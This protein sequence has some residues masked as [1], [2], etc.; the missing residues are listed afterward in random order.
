MEKRLLLKDEFRKKGN[1][2]KMKFG[3]D[4]GMGGRGSS[5]NATKR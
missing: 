2:S 3:Q 5:T 1:V 4:G